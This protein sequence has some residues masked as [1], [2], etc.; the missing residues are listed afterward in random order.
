MLKHLTHLRRKAEVQ[1]GLLEIPKIL[2]DRWSKEKTR[3]RLKRRSTLTTI[4]ERHKQARS[5]ARSTT[6]LRD[7]LGLSRKR[8]H[9][10][11]GYIGGEEGSYK[12]KSLPRHRTH[13]RSGDSIGDAEP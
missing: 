5:P 11:Q 4:A 10:A 12:K 2:L 7:T 8:L 3:N 9:R 13:P 1:P 6:T